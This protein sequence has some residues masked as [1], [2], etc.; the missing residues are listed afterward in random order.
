MREENVKNMLYIILWHNNHSASLNY[1]RATTNNKHT[2]TE[3]RSH[4]I[5]DVSSFPVMIDYDRFKES[6]YIDPLHSH[7]FE[8][9]YSRKYQI[10][11]IAWYA[12]LSLNKN[13]EVIYTW[14]CFVFNVIYNF[15]A[16]CYICF[17]LIMSA[18]FVIT[19]VWLVTEFLKNLERAAHWQ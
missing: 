16:F 7:C 9:Q 1:L 11:W 6:V 19:C 5:T 14:K 3:T 2:I 18:N 17:A 10:K 12:V 4:C 13:T 8:Y 15:F